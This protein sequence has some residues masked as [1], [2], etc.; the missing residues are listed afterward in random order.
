MGDW[1]APRQELM[2]FYIGLAKGE[3]PELIFDAFIS[4]EIRPTV[5]YIPIPAAAFASLGMPSEDRCFDYRRMGGRPS[6][7]SGTAAGACNSWKRAL[8][9]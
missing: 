2:R 8:K 3:D 4:W 6:G 9:A 1:E 5:E 7:S